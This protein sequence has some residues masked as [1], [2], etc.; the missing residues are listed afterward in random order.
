MYWYNDRTFYHSNST[1]LLKVRR[2]E[3]VG[4]QGWSKYDC[5]VQNIINIFYSTCKV[6]VSFFEKMIDFH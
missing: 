4:G 5:F 2:F 6:R 3:Q 1:C